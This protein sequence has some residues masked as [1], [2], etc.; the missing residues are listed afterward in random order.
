MS[1]AVQPAPSGSRCYQRRRPEHTLWDR[2]VQAQFETW[3]A[4]TAASDE[5]APPA[6]VEQAFRRYLE[7]G[8]LSCGFGR[9]FCKACG[10]DFLVA[11]SCRGRAVCPKDSHF[12]GPTPSIGGRCTP[13]NRASASRIG[14]VAHPKMSILPHARGRR[15]GPWSRQ[16]SMLAVGWTEDTGVP[17]PG[18]C[19]FLTT[20]PQIADEP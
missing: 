6:Y 18:F 11:F 14:V 16:R 19:R 3:L 1:A 13:V 12:K 9:A 15:A 5:T 2:T 17:S 20:L 8:I 7:C 10:H 4:L